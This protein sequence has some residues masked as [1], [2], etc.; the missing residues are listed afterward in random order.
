LSQTSAAER[1][2]VRAAE[3]RAREIEV[4]RGKV[5]QNLCSTYFGREWI[6]HKLE[7]CH[8]FVSVY[9]DLPSRMGLNEGRRQVG[10]ELLADIMRWCPDQFLLAM[11]EANDRRIVAEQSTDERSVVDEQSGS[12]DAGWD[13]EGS[14][15]ST[16]L[17]YEGN[18]NFYREFK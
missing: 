15:D 18:E 3:K 2:A 9:N 10:L 5:I 14:G 17:D 12:E 8:C 6:W 7:S 11:R 16:G 1:K 4:E 13:V